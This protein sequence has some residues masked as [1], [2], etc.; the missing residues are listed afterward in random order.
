LKILLYVFGVDMSEEENGN[1]N[2]KNYIM[3][4]E[5]NI[6]LLEEFKPKDRLGFVKGIVRCIQIL[7][8]S[9]KG[10]A[11]WVGNYEILD[12]LTLEELEEIYPQMKQLVIDFVKLDLAITKKKFSEVEAKQKPKSK[13]RKNYVS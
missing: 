11:S 2:T 5:E 10:W 4:M 13:D 6:K 1:G 9:I 12:D 3:A 8:V 7:N